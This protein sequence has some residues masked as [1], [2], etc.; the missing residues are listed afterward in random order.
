MEVIMNI[1]QV[2]P[3]LVE[4]ERKIK[5]HCAMGTKNKLEPLIQFTKEEFKE[6]QES[7]N[8]KNFERE[9]IL[10]IIYM[11]KG[12]YLFGGL[13]K[14]ISVNEIIQK[15]MVRKYIYKTELMDNIGGEF[16]GRMVISFDKEFRATYLKYENHSNDLIISEIRKQRYKFDPFPGYNDFYISFDLLVEVINTNESS[17]KTALSTVNGIYLISDTKN[18]KLYVGSA[19]GNDS[20]WGRW[21]NYIENGHGGNK[22]LKEII[23]KNGYEYSSNFMFSILEIFNFNTPN[24]EIISRESFWKE[25]L[26]TREYGY[27]D[28]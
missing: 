23:L 11:N 14:S 18:G 26:L 2:I 4:N 1:S 13:Y 25:K 21:S 27:N 15:D 3:F 6:W 7:Q 12:E 17:W 9:Y 24:N 5:I 19:Y 16:I 10:S 22:K 20:F 8:Q 28:N